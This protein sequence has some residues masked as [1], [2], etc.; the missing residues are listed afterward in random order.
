VTNRLA[1]ETSPYLLQHKD[2]PVDWYPWGDE[3]LTRAR[4]EDR[5]ILVSIGYSSCH[6]CHV[7]EHESFSDPVTAG[8]MNESFVC[9]K[10]DR[11]ERPDIDQIYM[12]AVQVMGQRGGWPLNM[13]LLPDMTPFFGGTYWPPADRQGM[14]A[15]QRV[16]TAI[17]DTY[18][19]RRDD[20]LA[21]A[22]AL[23]DYL[24]QAS[25]TTPDPADIQEDVLLQAT[26]QLTHRA[27]LELG[28]WG[29]A[30]KFPQPMVLDF[31]MARYHQ[32][33][34]PV[35]QSALTTTLTRMADGGMYDQIG[36]GFHRYSVD[37]EWL[38]PHFEKMLYDNAQLLS[39]Y[40]DGWLLFRDPRY[41]EIA[42]QTA[43]YLL[44]EMAD[45][46]GGF[47]SATDA[48]SDG[49]EGTFFIWTP[50]EI[51]AVLGPDDAAAVIAL[52]GVTETGNFEGENIL[53]RPRPLA[54]V[55]SDLGRTADE[56][57]AVT[58][59]AAPLLL[60]ARGQRNPPFRDDKVIASW[61]GLLLHALARAARVLRRPDLLAAARASGTFLTT[62]ILVD[63]QL[64]RSWKSGVAKGAGFLE[65]YAAV[66]FGLISL[67]DA[68]FDAHWLR[69]AVSLTDEAIER[70]ADP[71]SGIFYDTA[72]DHDH[73]LVRPRE[74]QDGATPS[75]N[76]LL[77]DT[78]VRLAR[79]TG[80]EIYRERADGI[81][82]G[83]SAPLGE[84]PLGFGR[85]L[86][87]ANRYLS[88]EREIVLAGDRDDPAFAALVDEM[89][90][91]YKPLAVRAW[92]DPTDPAI[93]GLLPV[94]ADRTAAG[95]RATAYVCVDH[96]C[97]LPVTDAAS[98]SRLLMETP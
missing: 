4:D 30:P 66:A 29:P 50:E 21:N 61:N 18:R 64:H 20:V 41:R 39:T 97:S 95:G 54:V 77:A 72:G 82:R 73:L 69:E 45:S 34:D 92:A 11:E 7:M 46:G 76:A 19:S 81:L 53:N 27:D 47:Y 75:G 57:Q 80:R 62:A 15:F 71:D 3:A 33:P 38:V 94:T 90:D 43:T 17:S 6:W 91:H 88:P 13:F 31:A 42:D 98:L 1:H 78:L 58:D 59:R 96:I 22:G 25:R 16:L 79:L 24:V 60:A 89:A 93:A 86:S 14:P 55:A 85:M 74:L 51:R 36:G 23:R 48:D 32:E 2:N 28:G 87:V 9:I 56:L 8:L 26:D 40:L 70:F 37:A 52:Y 67:Y 49:E 35:L 63:G 83:M 44:R 68:T 65:D 10:V 84:A 5:P 12:T